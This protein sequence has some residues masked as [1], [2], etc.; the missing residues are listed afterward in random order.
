VT[1]RSHSKIALAGLAAV[2]MSLALAACGG[3]DDKT[4]STTAS[5]AT[6]D[7]T[8]AAEAYEV[9]ITQYLAHPSLDLITQGFKDAL[10]EKGLA[11]GTDI[12]YTYRDAGG[13]DPNTV[14][15]ASEFAAD[16]KYDLILAVAT[17]SA[18]A[19][20]QKEK[21][22]PVLFAGITD[23]VAAELVKTWDAS[24]DNG[25]V[26]GTS[27]LNPEGKPLGMIQEIMGDGNVSKVGFIYSLSEKN[28]EVQ[29]EA[30]KAEAE[31]T[32]IEIVPAGISNASELAVGLEALGGVDAIF[33]GTDN[34]VVDALEQ[35]VSFG[36]KNQIPL[37]VADAAS[38]E[39]G[40]VATRGI[41]Y[42]ELGKRTGEMAYDILVNGV[43]PSSI[44]PLAVIDTVIQ[45]NPDAAASYGITIPESVLSAAEIVTSSGTE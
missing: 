26:T 18:Q 16:S 27:D 36:V 15:I 45:A 14:T 8:A 33:V 43:A 34:T 3:G 28:S 7:S 23:P 30:L 6:G 9:A 29:L 2:A 25:N 37:F 12:N 13:E 1:T 42:Y 5:T 38:V 10:S 19:V 35:V 31:G 17:P 39:R 21:T 44:A 24:A 4:D 41:D 32:G 22:R 11:D 40:G 20:V